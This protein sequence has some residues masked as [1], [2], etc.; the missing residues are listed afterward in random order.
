M[1]AHLLD[2][3]SGRSSRR[4]CSPSSRRRCNPLATSRRADLLTV[5]LDRPSLPG[6]VGAIVRTADAFGATGVVVTGHAADPFDPRS[7]HRQPRTVFTSA[8]HASAESTDG[9]AM[10]RLLRSCQASRQRADETGDVD[11]TDAAFDE[12]LVIVLGNEARGMG[13]AWRDRCDLRVRIPMRGRASSLNVAAA[14]AVLLYEVD[15]PTNS[16][17][18]MPRSGFPPVY[19]YERLAGAKAIAEALPGGIVDLSIG[20]PCDPPPAG[21]RRRAGVGRRAGLPLLRG[22]R[23]LPRG[24]IR[25]DGAGG[26]ASRSLPTKW[27]PASAPRSSWPR[28]PS[29]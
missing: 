15:S 12:P 27:P 5:V 4:N 20:T 14:A 23:P 29:G 21:G 7:G 1:P 8:Y 17:R 18:L 24:G 10:A 19:P 2:Q 3:L 11:L 26:S 9:Y 25:V 16:V 6:N 22:Q 13:A 28:C